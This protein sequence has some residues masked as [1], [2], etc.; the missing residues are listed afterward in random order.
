M[1]SVVLHEPALECPVRLVCP[2]CRG[3][4]SMMGKDILCDSCSRRY[5]FSGSVPDLIVGGKF[6]DTEPE[7]Q[8]LYEE[9]CNQDTTQNFWI[10]RFRELFGSETAPRLLS[11]GCGTGADV[12]LLTDAGFITIGIDN[13]NRARCWTRRRHRHQLVLANGKHIPFPDQS[14]DG[15]FCGCV[16]PHVGVIGDSRQVAPDGCQ[17]RLELAREM[18]RVLKPGG[19][20]LV[21]SPNRLFPLD[22]FHGRSPGSYRPRWS[23]PWHPFLLSVRDYH[24]LFQRAGC[25]RGEAQPVV[26]YWGF[27]RSK[28][29]LKGRVLGAPLRALFGIVSAPRFRF[30]AGSA[31]NPWIVVLLEKPRSG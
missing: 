3:E 20:I 12:D 30:L 22:I 13:G 4:L 18:T 6:E 8:I 19:K 28:N 24:H 7:E 27:I 26:G 31:V 16:F 25:V 5:T 9:R 10:P 14:F 21:S 1:T 23:S 11:L 15:V 29:S 17:Q 2:V